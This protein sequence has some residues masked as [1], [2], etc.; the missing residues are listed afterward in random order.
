MKIW[1]TQYQDKT[2]QFWNSKPEVHCHAK[3]TTCFEV[4]EELPVWEITRWAARGY[5]PV[6]D[7]KFRA[8]W[9]WVPE[10]VG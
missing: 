10:A 6:G 3:G 9:G 1:I 7:A 8:I 4:D 2:M 5:P